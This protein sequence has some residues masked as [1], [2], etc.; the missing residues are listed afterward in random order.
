MGFGMGSRGP[1]CAGRRRRSTM[2]C[3]SSG[4]YAA[5]RWPYRAA[6]RPRRRDDRAAA[7]DRG[8]QE[9]AR[10]DD[11]HVHSVEAIVQR[12]REFL[13]CWSQPCF[14]CTADENI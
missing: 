6:R 4:G 3:S 10:G 11:Y 13:L 2:G 14:H 1:A 7:W 12:W 8:P 9:H 5:G